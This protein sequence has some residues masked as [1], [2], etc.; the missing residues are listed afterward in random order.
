MVECG[1]D[2]RAWRE[3]A[4]STIVRDLYIVIHKIGEEKRAPNRKKKA[5]GSQMLRARM[6][7]LVQGRGG[8]RLAGIISMVV[9][10]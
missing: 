6:C 2:Q 9:I 3:P 4:T 1:D 5:S 7:G 10:L 8:A